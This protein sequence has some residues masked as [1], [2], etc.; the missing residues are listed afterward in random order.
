[1]SLSRHSLEDLRDRVRR[2]RDRRTLRRVA[3]ALRGDPRKGARALAEA[4]ER[5][6]AFERADVL[7]MARLLSRLRG[8]RRRGAR[9]VAG[10]DEVGVGPLA[11]PVVAAAVVFGDALDLP[12]LD[13][14][15]RLRRRE[16]ERPDAAIRA[17]AVAVSVAEV[18]VEEIDRLNVYHAGLE[19]MRRAVTQ[20]A[21]RADHLLVDARTIPGLDT[22][23]TAI[24]AG[25]ACDASIA[26]AS[27]V[28][29]TYR[30]ALM[31][32]YD[33]RYPVYGF[34]RHMGYPTAQHTSALRRHGPCPI[35]R[36]SFAPVSQCLLF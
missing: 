10:V 36:L 27:V 16:R 4:C 17:Q 11:G 12:G 2:A 35:H 28:A 1:M 26:A 34:R 6:L 22:P 9:Y 13:D 15:K 7:R 23:Q 33:L 24:V 19:A 14:S 8:L 18:S 20:L 25:D 21:V 31:R 5:R 30:D 32:R 29:K 3:A